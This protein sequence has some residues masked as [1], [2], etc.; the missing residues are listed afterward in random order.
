LVSA[1]TRGDGGEGVVR[2]LVVIAKVSEGSGAL[3]KIPQ[4]G[5]IL[6]F[7]KGVLGGEAVRDGLGTLGEEGGGEKNQQAEALRE[8]H[9][10]WRVPEA[11]QRGEKK[12]TTNR[13]RSGESH[14]CPD[15]FTS[16]IVRS[17]YAFVVSWVGSD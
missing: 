13:E 6:L 14:A 3:G 11:K 15:G 2:K 9:R 12:E 7:E 16:L 1:V 17:G 8:A 4:V 5:L 10:Y